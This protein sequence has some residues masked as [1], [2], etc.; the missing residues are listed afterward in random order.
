M[1]MT[2]RGTH[3]SKGAVISRHP[4]LQHRATRAK[5]SKAML[6]EPCT[7]LDLTQVSRSLSER[8]SSPGAALSA[9]ALSA[10]VTI[11]TLEPLSAVFGRATFHT[12]N[13]SVPC[14]LRAPAPCVKAGSARMRV[15]E[16]ASQACCKV[17]RDGR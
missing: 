4:V 8:L 10:V 11:V 2:L 6:P 16:A 5:D 1:Y 9:S 13:V 17:H 14:C 3:T 7:I 12:S 15:V